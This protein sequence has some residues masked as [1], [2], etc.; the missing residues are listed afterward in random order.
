MTNIEKY[1]IFLVEQYREKSNLTARE[2]YNL[3][4]KNEIFEYIEETFEAIHT[5]DSAEIV[6]EIEEKIKTKGEIL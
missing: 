5:Q 2:V 1:K 6:S 3:F 4:K